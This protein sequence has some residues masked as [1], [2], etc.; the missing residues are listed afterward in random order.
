MA[1]PSKKPAEGRFLGAQYYGV[2]ARLELGFDK[3]HTS[4]LRRKVIFS[5]NYSRF[6]TQL[7]ISEKVERS[8]A[9]LG[10]W[11][12]LVPRD[13]LLPPASWALGALCAYAAPAPFGRFLTRPGHYALAMLPGELR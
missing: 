6:G 7:C 3:H 4:E 9:C 12:T 5:K 8:L 13:P 11:Y 10:A 2:L 1:W